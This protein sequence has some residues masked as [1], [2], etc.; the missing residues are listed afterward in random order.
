[1]PYQLH[2]C[3]ELVDA[4]LLLTLLEIEEILLLTLLA[5]LLDD[6]EALL[7]DKLLC[8]ELLLLDALLVF[9]GPLNNCD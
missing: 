3:P 8:D 4:E 7:L 6:N 9:I 2:F 5:K 1:M